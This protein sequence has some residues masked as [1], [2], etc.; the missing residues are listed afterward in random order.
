MKV[1]TAQLLTVLCSERPHGSL[2][3]AG[4]THGADG[5]TKTPTRETL[6][7]LFQT[8]G[9]LL[10]ERLEVAS[11][12]SAEAG[13]SDRSVEWEAAQALQTQ[14]LNLEGVAMLETAVKC[15]DAVAC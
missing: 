10:V 4:V 12:E 6:V 7:S 1:G 11:R 14:N 8:A 3:I 5:L 13:L 2:L 15:P 9:L